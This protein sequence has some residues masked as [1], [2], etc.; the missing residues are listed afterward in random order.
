MAGLPL[1]DEVPTFVNGKGNEAYHWARRQA[2]EVQNH[3]MD[4]LGERFGLQLYPGTTS[5]LILPRRAGRAIAVAH[6]LQADDFADDGTLVST[7]RSRVEREGIE[8]DAAGPEGDGEVESAAKEV[9]DARIMDKE[10]VE[11]T[12]MEVNVGEAVRPVSRK[13]ASK[14]LLEQF[15]YVLS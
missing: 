1:T 3:I 13:M 9:E 12:S 11:D 10:P 5:F 7:T 8:E 4:S 14:Q 15:D 6:I 2:A